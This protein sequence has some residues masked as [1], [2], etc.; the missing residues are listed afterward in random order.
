MKFKVMSF[1]LRYKNQF[2]GENGWYYRRDK[3]IKMITDNDPLIVGTQEGLFPV[4]TELDQLL[5]DYN[6]V[7]EGRLGGTKGEYS[8]IFYKK[9]QLEIVA[10]DQFW[11]SETPTEVGSK[12]WGS[13]LPRICTW[14]HFRSIANPKKEFICFNT[15]LDHMSQ[16]AREQGILLI[17]KN[18][19]E[20]LSQKSLPLILTGDFNSETDN[21]VV[22]FLRGKTTIDGVCPDIRDAYTVL[23][24]EIGTTFHDFTGKIEGEPIDYIFVTPDI[25]V[26]NVKVD[27]RKIDGIY[28]SDHYPVISELVIAE[29]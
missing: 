16:E 23:D 17:W 12:S 3:V 22:E 2:D 7:G 26:L 13:S 10:S 1:N 11:L 29:K 20:A 25:T 14:T 15:H 8:A 21:E 6:Y 28:P 9:D 27:R 18:M 4:I 19:L 5:D 24:G